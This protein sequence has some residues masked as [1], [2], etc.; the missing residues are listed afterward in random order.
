ME[1]M[2]IEIGE[3]TLRAPVTAGTNLALAVQRP[4]FPPP[5]SRAG[6]AFEALE[7]LLLDDGDRDFRGG[8]QARVP[9]RAV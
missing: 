8:L 5:Q 6:G 4:L 9:A 3:F 2:W 1:T 7:W